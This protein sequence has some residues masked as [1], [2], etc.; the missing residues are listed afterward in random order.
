MSE[1]LDLTDDARLRLLELAGGKVSSGL[2]NK[3]PTLLVI[4]GAGVS[5]ASAGAPTWEQLLINGC[6]FALP[7]YPQQSSTVEAIRRRIIR[8]DWLGAA[9]ELR[10]LLSITHFNEFL[11]AQFDGFRWNRDNIKHRSVYALL[12]I[13]RRNG[14]RIATTN[15]DTIIEDVLSMKEMDWRDSRCDSFF[16]SE[17]PAINREVLHIHGDYQRPD[18]VVFDKDDYQRINSS[19]ADSQRL[20]DNLLHMFRNGNVL[21]VGCGQTTADPHFQN[22]FERCMIS[23]A[24]RHAYL[25]SDDA[26]EGLRYP[27]GP[28]LPSTV[29]LAPYGAFAGLPVAL[30]RLF[31]AIFDRIDREIATSQ[32][33]RARMLNRQHR[34]IAAHTTF[35]DDAMFLFPDDGLIND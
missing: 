17:D 16:H 29:E 26:Y 6:D 14:A 30:K 3:P 22:I 13:L 4:V 32:H 35:T 18:S 27:R 1:A 34:A 7:R 8:E 9:G 21:F 25:C 33:R 20:Q 19:L 10:R 24:T 15:Y 11:M 23:A 5:I 2:N 31:P 12:R 28:G